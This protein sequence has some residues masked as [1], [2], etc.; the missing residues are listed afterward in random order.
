MQ[1]VHHGGSRASTRRTGFTLVEVSIVSLL[2]AC[3]T[4]GLTLAVQFEARAR[5][6]VG[7][8]TNAERIADDLLTRLDS[9]LTS[10]EAAHPRGRFT[11]GARAL[12]E[13]PLQGSTHDDSGERERLLRR[14]DGSS[15]LFREPGARASKDA[16]A[17][18]AIF[19]EPVATI[20]EADRDLDVNAD[21][22]LDDHFDLGAL[23]QRSWRAHEPAAET[24]VP[25][26]IELCPPILL[27]ERGAWGSDLDG[28]GSDDPIFRFDPQ[29]SLCIRL[30]VLTG[31]ADQVGVVVRKEI[32]LFLAGQSTP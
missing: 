27:Q 3:L 14:N 31:A 17:W 11:P 24:P 28:D 30:S 23:R 22:D 8:R 4:L 6:G 29:G 19:F 32:D 10:V 26:E 15:F 20:R 9:V 2:L 16:G 13:A 18:S 7:R 21:G 5:H 1:P 25:T 12:D